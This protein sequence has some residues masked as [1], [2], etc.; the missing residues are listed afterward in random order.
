VVVGAEPDTRPPSS[1]H[2]GGSCSLGGCLSQHDARGVG[3]FD[4]VRPGTGG[5][6]G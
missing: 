2:Q 4:R 1:R 5:C 6:S 3:T